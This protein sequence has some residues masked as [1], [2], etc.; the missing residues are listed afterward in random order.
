MTDHGPK[1]ESRADLLKLSLGALG[2]VYGDIGTSPLYAVRE[3][4]S[5]EHGGL[6]PNLPSVLGVLSLVFWS[7]AIVV[8]VKYLTLVMRADNHGDG[9]ILALLALVMPPGGRQR[10]FGLVALGLFGAALLWADGMITPAIS[11][12]GAIEGLKVA[13]PFFAPYVVPLSV[14]VLVALFLVQKRGT[15]GIGAMF[16]PVMLAWFVTIAVLGIPWILREP[17]VLRALNPFYGIQLL[18]FHGMSG[19]F[20][21]GSVVLC[22][23]GAEALYA[24]MGHFGRGPIR[25]AWYALV[26]PALLLNYF[27]QGALLIR[28]GAEVTANP[29]Y[30]LAPQQLVIPL[31]VLATAAAVIASQALISGAFSLA[32]QT[33]Q[34]GYAP[35]LTIVHTSASAYG[36]IYV[37]EVNAALAAACVGLVFAFR[38]SSNLAAAYGIAV[39]GTMAVTS[40][41]LFAVAVR[42]W[43]WNVWV[44]VAVVGAF[45]TV[46]LAFLAGNMP[47]LLHG[48]WFPLVVG[49]AMFLLMRTWKTGRSFLAERLSRESLPLEMFMAQ[50]PKA[51]PH[52]V[53]G[54]AV[55]MTPNV[56]VAPV[57]MLHHFKHNKVLHEKVVLLSIVI[58]G[59]PQVEASKRIEL[60]DLG[61][62]FYQL[63][64][65]SGF[66][67]NT[68]VTE[69][70]AAAAAQ[71]LHARP[72]QTSFYLGR[73][74]LLTTGPARM[75]RWRKALFSFMS[76]NARPATG[77]FGIP[78]NRVVELG[79]QIEL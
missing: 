74:S 72:D 19:I 47:K 16:G 76:R 24:D 30:L 23:T 63:I 33:V 12:L 34:L 43:K 20:V 79:T 38:S 39:V 77:F 62:G 56:N 17:G 66:M 53:P 41:L 7:L 50:L 69:I 8:V 57:V 21:L 27:G 3:Y 18:A 71:G 31:A 68:N 61:S 54:T 29:F 60:N 73:E 32:Q 22:V 25:I 28:R 6:S 67:E 1:I 37:P 10:A 40:C 42:R 78:P 26:F 65:R 14:I 15:A 46:D 44:A 45:L 13:T 64:A 70:L 35:R 4:F 5:P 59:V 58:E 48:G 2:V 11:V 49:A 52:R 51:K 36:Q 9:G 75:A 55:F